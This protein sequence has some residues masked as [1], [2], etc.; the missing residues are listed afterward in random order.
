MSALDFKALFSSLNQVPRIKMKDLSTIK[1]TP[2]GLQAPGFGK[3]DPES[4]P[5]AADVGRSGTP[6]CPQQSK[7]ENGVGTTWLS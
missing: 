2:N 1:I 5:V 6:H 3:P 4:S 7:T